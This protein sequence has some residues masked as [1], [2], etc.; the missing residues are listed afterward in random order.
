MRINDDYIEAC[1]RANPDSSVPEAF[2]RWSAIS[3]VSSALARRV[4]YDAGEFKIRPNTY[5]VLVGAP[6]TGKSLSLA[7]PYYQVLYPISLSPGEVPEN[8]ENKPRIDKY[9]IK[10]CPTYLLEDRITPEEITVQLSRASYH[11][12]ILST[13]N[14]TTVSST[15]TLITS[16]FGTLMARESKYLPIFLTDL[17]DG[18]KPVQADRSKTSG[19]FVVRNAS[20]NWIA[21]ATPDQFV[22][23]MPGNAR[24]QGLLSRIIIV[25][26]DGPRRQED[27]FF[28][29]PNPIKIESLQHDLAQI[30]KM[31]GPMVFEPSI[32]DRVRRE[33]RLGIPPRPTD[34]NLSEYLERRFPH[35]MKLAIIISASRRDN[36][37]IT[38]HDWE[39]AKALLFDAEKHMPKALARFGMGDAG[40]MTANS[41]EGTIQALTSRRKSV[42]N[43]ASLRRRLLKRNL[44]AFT[45]FALIRLASKINLVE[46][47]DNEL[48][49]NK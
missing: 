27:I 3:S 23:H 35:L 18:S 14:N 26:Y 37:I 24:N 22:T 29:A 21:C 30:S 1:V 15:I 9:E 19:K 17:W 13:P 48:S 28:G 20:L 10:D 36:G 7:I 2:R 4:W 39:T 42:I 5:I 40:T 38:G 11:D 25:Y 44:S 32:L 43:M 33:V 45:I 46:N 12:Q 49:E 34:K 47:S 6:G 41:F 31:R 8:C 16:E